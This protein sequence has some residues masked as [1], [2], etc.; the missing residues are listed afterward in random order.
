MV[1]IFMVRIRVRTKNQIANHNIAATAVG[2][3]ILS[4][5]EN[6]TASMTMATKDVKITS[7]KICNVNT[8]NRKRVS[9]APM[10]DPKNTPIDPSTDLFAVIL[11]LCLP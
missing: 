6:D 1:Y 2:M 11:Y 8:S 9:I 10:K 4:K 3:S 5:K 7:K